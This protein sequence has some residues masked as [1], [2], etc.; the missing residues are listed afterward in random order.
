[1]ITN[2]ELGAMRGRCEYTESSCN[3]TTLKTLGLSALKDIPALLDE[4]D[5]LRGELEVEWHAHQVTKLE[6]Q[7]YNETLNK[8]ARLKSNAGLCAATEVHTLAWQA[9]EYD[10]NKDA[11][12]REATK[13]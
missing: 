13:E 8:L 9:L 12:H 11:V 6:W 4:V 7:K 1:M 2:K 5:R 3:E 10:G